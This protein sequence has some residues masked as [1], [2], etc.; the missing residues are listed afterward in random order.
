MIHTTPAKGPALPEDM[1][2][3]P[4]WELK[5]KTTKAFFVVEIHGYG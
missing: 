4:L 1:R 5:N 2:C 3:L